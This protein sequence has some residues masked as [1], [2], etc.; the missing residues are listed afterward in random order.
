MLKLE[1]P[2]A[3]T[4]LSV[5]PQ[6]LPCDPRT[7]THRFTRWYAPDDACGCAGRLE[8]SGPSMDWTAT[9]TTTSEEEPDA[10]GSA[11]KT[12][13]TRTAKRARRREQQKAAQQRYRRVEARAV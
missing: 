4:Q 6:L 3:G 1:C 13:A 8:C 12:D 9:G 7:C 5:R 2:P 10:S 11:K